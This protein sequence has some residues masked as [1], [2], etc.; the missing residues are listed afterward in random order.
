MPFVYTPSAMS[1]VSTGSIVCSSSSSYVPPPT[2]SPVAISSWASVKKPLSLETVQESVS[3][4]PAVSVTSWYVS[5]SAK[6][7]A[8]LSSRR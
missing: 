3:S 6:P 1:K 5:S 2:R 7:C 4:P 8:P